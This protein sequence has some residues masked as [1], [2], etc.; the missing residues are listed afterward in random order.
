MAELLVEPV[1][2]SVEDGSFTEPDAE[3]LVAAPDPCFFAFFL[4][5]RL[6]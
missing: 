2:V 5:S 3:P 1:V 6:E 4:L